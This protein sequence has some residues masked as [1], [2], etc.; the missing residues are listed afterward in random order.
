LTAA[1][2]AIVVTSPK[3]KP[4]SYG[5]Q[6]RGQGRRECRRIVPSAPGTVRDRREYQP[7]PELLRRLVNRFR[8]AHR[9]PVGK[10]YICPQAR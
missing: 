5:R 8:V 3:P 9:F 1:V 7:G 2:I 6:Q 10:N 4:S